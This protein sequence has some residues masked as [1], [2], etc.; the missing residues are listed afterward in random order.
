[1]TGLDCLLTGLVQV[2]KPA[3]SAVKCQGSEGQ[4]SSRTI[5][6]VLAAQELDRRQFGTISRSRTQEARC[7]DGFQL[8]PV[9]V[10]SSVPSY[11]FCN[12]E[13]CFMLRLYLQRCYLEY[14][15]QN[16]F[17][18]KAKVDE[19]TSSLFQPMITKQFHVIVLIGEA[20]ATISSSK[21]TR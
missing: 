12:F 17:T 6:A 13:Q 16:G 7:K 5:F 2:G 8:V 20:E 11:F 10:C 4:K 9:P 1:M 3:T 15:F 21:Q 19:A 14:F 18:S